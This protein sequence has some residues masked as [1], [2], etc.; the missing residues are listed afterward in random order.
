TPRQILP[1]II[2][3]LNFGKH[4]GFAAF[5]AY[6][7]GKAAAWR[8]ERAGM[9]AEPIAWPAELVRTR[10]DARRAPPPTAC[11]GCDGGQPGGHRRRWVRLALVQAS[12]AA[13]RTG[14]H[15]LEGAGAR[16]YGLQQAAD[17]DPSVGDRLFSLCRADRAGRQAGDRRHRHAAADERPV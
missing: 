2:N 3:G 15:H 1:W 7:A 10:V 5:S 16:R 13:P 12:A 4:Y 11:A 9:D 8:A 14:A 6:V 17:H